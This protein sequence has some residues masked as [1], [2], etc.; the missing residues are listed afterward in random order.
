MDI[1]YNKERK[2]FYLETKNT[3]YIFHILENGVLEHLYYG[4]KISKNDDIRSTANH[5]VYSWSLSKNE[6]RTLTNANIMLECSFNADGDYRNPTI[7]FDNKVDT[8]F[9]YQ[10]HRIYKGRMD[11]PQLP[12]ARNGERVNTLEIVLLNDSKDIE[13]TLF[14]VSYY[15]SDVITRYIKIKNLTNDELKIKK[16]HS[17]CL[18]F[19]HKLFDYLSL[20]GMYNY[21]RSDIVRYPLHKGYQGSSSLVGISSHFVNPFFALLSPKTNENRGDVFGFNLIYSGNFK[22]IVEVDRL[23]QTRV[24]YGINEETFYYSLK[25]LEE[26]CTPEAVMTFSKHGLNK[27]SQNFHNFINEYI[28]NNP[29]NYRP[30]VFNSWEGHYFDVDEATIHSLVDQALSVNADTVVIDD[31]WF[32]NDDKGGLGDWQYVKDKFPHGLKPVEEYI[33][34]KGLKFGLWIEPEMIS[35]DSNLYKEHKDIISSSNIKPL[36]SRH[37]FIIDLTR[38]ENVELVS[39]ILINAF[40]DLRIDYIKWDF[41][42]YIGDPGSDS[43]KSG[44]VFHKQ[45]LGAYKLLENIKKA[46][47][48]VFIEGCAG[49]GGRF[50]LGMLYYCPQIWASDNTDPYNRI[51]IQYGT[52]IAYPPSTISCHFTKGECISG[53][54]SS[55]DFRYK[56][57]SFGAYGYE[58]DIRKNNKDDIEQL[59]ELTNLYKL[60]TSLVFEGDLYRLI[61]PLGDKFVSY[62]QVS[63]DRETAIFTFL[64][65]NATGLYENVIVK[66]VGLNNKFLYKNSLSGEVLSGKALM[67][68]G[69]RVKDLYK[70]KSGSG[71]QIVFTRELDNEA[72]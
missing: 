43:T 8:H 22:N 27:M 42:R 71:I 7:Y 50:D 35:L 21:E 34:S 64:Q 63:K 56:V 45:I 46:F 18:D 3:S 14:Y 13:I 15:K 2:S 44:E 66:L 57:A 41:N 32:R 61:S 68:V 28:V 60:N 24:N 48:H 26:F 33:H 70:G 20:Y 47:P 62:I 31:G 59:K 9:T 69:V 53:K 65:I 1:I 30:V 19:N 10:S 25:S 52:S 23:E 67:K 51:Y 55:I 4:D 17:L 12:H 38:D 36:Q 39:N 5:Q 72:K 37:Q 49:G 58:L 6:D 29:M 16:A 54:E 11:I 40:K